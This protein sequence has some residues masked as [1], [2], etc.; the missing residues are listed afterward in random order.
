MLLADMGIS[1]RTLNALAAKKIL[2]TYDIERYFPYKY[3][4]YRETYALSDAVGKDVAVE[5]YVE[6]VGKPQNVTPPQVILEGIDLASGEHL[7]VKWFGN[8]Y[9][10]NT[11]KSLPFKEAVVCG[12]VEYHPKYGYSMANP[13]FCR[14]KP[15]HEPKI[16][17]V[18]RKMKGISEN[19]L[20]LL[21]KKV[22]S[23][24]TDPIPSCINAKTNLPDYKSALY[25]LH[26]PENMESIEKAK[27][28]IIFN[29]ML[30]FATKLKTL[31]KT[32]KIQSG[33]F[34]ISKQTDMNHYLNSL[35]YTLTTDQ[36][37][38]ITQIANDMK[39]GILTNALIQG[40]VGCGKTTVAIAIM[41]LVAENGYQSALLVPS[42]ALAQQHY[43]E[44]KNIAVNYGYQA[45]L[46]TTDVKGKEKK[47]LLNEIK[48]GKIDFIIGTHSLFSECVEYKNLALS[49]VDEEHKF[50][51]AQR[52]QLLKKAKADD[53]V[54]TGIHSILMSATPIPRTLAEIR[55]GLSR[56]LYNIMS[57]PSG[58]IPVQTAINHSDKVI[59]DFI[60]REL[61]AGRQCYVICP[62][63][64]DAIMTTEEKEAR[65]VKLDSVVDVTNKYANYFSQFGYH[66]ASVTGRDKKSYL[67]D[68]LDDF[69]S[70]KIQILVS[71]TVIEVG[72]NVPN[73]STIV[74]HNAERFGLA[75]MHQ[76]R[77]RVGRGSDKSYCILY[78][79]DRENPRLKKMVET[80][81]GF[82]I[83]EADIA[84]RGT[85][86]LLGT[87]QNGFNHYTDLVMS[88]PN[89]YERTKAYA[90]WVLQKGYGNAIISAYEKDVE[91]LQK[92][93]TA[94]KEAV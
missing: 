74:I 9:I 46:L 56:K 45:A 55:Y 63:V 40:D 3:L 59:L 69:K 51:V 20:Q 47:R 66:V 54:P 75:Q 26:Y 39:N 31:E 36:L 65:S 43:A 90:E 70:N 52:E 94:H 72:V 14:Y 86:D 33:K 48:E 44:I 50:G 25:D 57:M 79:A 87:S 34:D 68:T 77:G 30:Y 28:K 27:H 84:L 2:T 12:K 73:A 21:I 67:K 60:K 93:E 61:D 17:P 91:K 92:I 13:Q 7:K 8:T 24:V 1:T 10:Y 42:V 16:Y 5:V 64:D 71:T 23:N 32:E 35:P 85:G 88:M 15:L 62:L 89:L 53:G 49:I 38:T 81:S 41:L 80:T 29:D 78:S 37:N 6:S 82:E 19:T 83:A 4:D 58:R 11:I 22:L 18:Y 76:L